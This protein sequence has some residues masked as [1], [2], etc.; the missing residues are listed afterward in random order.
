[1][2]RSPNRARRSL[3]ARCLLALTLLLG[4]RAWADAPSAPP[5]S[6]LVD[7]EALDVPEARDDEDEDEAASGFIVVPL[8]IYSPET[9]FGLG[10]FGAHY[11]RLPGELPESRVSSVAVVAFATT[12]RQVILEVLPELYWDADG[13]HVDA[14]VE[15]Q[16]FPDSFWGVGANT[17]DSAEERYLRERVRLRGV[18]RRR[19]VGPL[20]AGLSVD[21]MGFFPTI[22]DTEGI[23]ATQDVMGQEGGVT[24]GLGPTV[25]FD[26]R[27]NTL[28][29]RSGTL[30]SL[31]YNRFD[32]IWGS[33]Y[34]M[35]KVVAEA[36]QFFTLY[37][38]HALG[39]RLYGEA[40]GGDVPFYLTGMLGGDE[41]LRGY[42][43]GRYRD[44]WLAVAEAEYRF[45]IV[46][47][48]RGVVFAGAGE[49]ASRAR[50]M[51]FDPIRWST[52]GGLRVALQER[53]RLNL[54][55]D[56]GIGPGTRG[57]YLSATEAF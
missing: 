35:N 44:D 39:L 28:E 54:R 5:A 25:Q 46:W 13:F 33:Q 55:F 45:P 56:F 16:H 40:N 1:M 11:F 18:A 53:E 52:G 22:R 27:D 19:L 23:L 15:Y 24:S 10:G 57:F 38:G 37:P 49:V 42:F 30:L 4:G 2:W 48:F 6:A 12:R 41:L 20:Y 32:G 34:E 50:E 9:H 29:S 14:K 43:L 17:P 3:P 31:T 8:A 47:L 21:V 36:R 26:T 51:N 7:E